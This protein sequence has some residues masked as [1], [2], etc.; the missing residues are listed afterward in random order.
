MRWVDLGEVLSWGYPKDYSKRDNISE[1]LDFIW[2]QSRKP[3]LVLIDGRFR[4]ASFLTTLKHCELGTTIIFDDYL[5]RSHY[6][7]VEEMVLPIHL[8][9]RQAIFKIESKDDIDFKLLDELLEKF[10]YVMD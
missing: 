9:G 7:I 2:K 8:H 1:Y 6:H 5:K 4:V 10:M 3:D